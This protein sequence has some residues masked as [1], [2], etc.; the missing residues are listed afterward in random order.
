MM[1][2]VYVAFV[3][4]RSDYGRPPQIEDLRVIPCE[5]PAGPSFDRPHSEQDTLRAWAKQTVNRTGG[6]ALLFVAEVV[7]PD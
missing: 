2:L 6:T 4:R 5:C 3:I 1:T 7:E